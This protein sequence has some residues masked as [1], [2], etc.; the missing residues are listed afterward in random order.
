MKKLILPLLLLLSTML[1]C[2]INITDIVEPIRHIFSAPKATPNMSVGDLGSFF[3]GTSGHI[4]TLITFFSLFIS[5]LLALFTYFTYKENKSITEKIDRNKEYIDTIYEK[6]KKD[7][8]HEIDK[9]VIFNAKS[10]MSKIEDDAYRKIDNNIEKIS[11]DALEKLFDYQQ[12][13]FKINQAKKYAYEEVMNS[14]TLELSEKLVQSVIIQ[15]QYNETNNHDIPNLF[16]NNIQER[17]IPTAIKLSEFVE[18]TDIIIEYLE[19]LLKK[20]CLS[21]ANKSRIKDVLR[22]YYGWIEKKEK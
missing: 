13:V 4:S 14:R 8:E 21:Y 16:S 17:V 22:D 3:E 11:S 2:D 6:L 5:G 15:G 20:K 1:H 12:L 18:L 10:V 9:Q 7:I 19:K